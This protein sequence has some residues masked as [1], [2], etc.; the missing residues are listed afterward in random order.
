MNEKADEPKRQVHHHLTEKDRNERTL[1]KKSM[2]MWKQR[3]EC[4]RHYSNF[5]SIS[6]NCMRCSTK[7]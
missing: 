5:V 4:S 1:I 3:K 7:H 2:Y 6:V